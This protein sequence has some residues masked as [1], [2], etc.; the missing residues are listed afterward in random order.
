M[1]AAFLPPLTHSVSIIIIILLA[2]TGLGEEKEEEELEREKKRL[3]SIR[4]RREDGKAKKPTKL[5][6]PHVYARAHPT[7]RSLLHAQT[8][9]PRTLAVGIVR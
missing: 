2:N 9:R 8:A 4:T 3:N 6:Q 7:P 5:L 1:Y